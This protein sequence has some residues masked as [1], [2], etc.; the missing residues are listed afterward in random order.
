MVYQKFQDIINGSMHRKIRGRSIATKCQPLLLSSKGRA[1]KQVK[2]IKSNIIRK[3]KKK[4]PSY[5]MLHLVPLFTSSTYQQT[6]T[7]KTQ[8]SSMPHDF[9]TPKQTHL[10]NKT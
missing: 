9:T 2:Q 7:A 1:K 3:S 4:P 8:K 5:A 6:Q 10:S